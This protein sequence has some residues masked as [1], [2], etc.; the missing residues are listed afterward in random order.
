MK[1][2][3]IK[4]SITAGMIISLA[5]TGCG[6]KEIKENVEVKN[7]QTSETPETTEIP[8]ASELP[9]ETEQTY[10]KVVT[11]AKEYIENL[12]Y[13]D[14]KVFVPIDE[15][16]ETCTFTSTYDEEKPDAIYQVTGEFDLNQDEKADLIR[17]DIDPET[18]DATLSV[19]D[20][21]V[22]DS[23]YS[24]DTMKIVD[25]DTN[26]TYKEIVITDLGPSYD[27]TF[28][29]Y[30]YDGSSLIKLGTLGA[31]YEDALCFDGY[32]RLT[33]SD[34]FLYDLEPSIMSMYYDYNGTELTE[35][36]FDLTQVLNQEYTL[37]KT[38]DSI[39]FDENAEDSEEYMPDWGET[40]EEKKL[41][42]NS[43]DKI[44]IKHIYDYERF[45][46]QLPDGRNGM[47]YFWIGD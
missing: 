40:C 4:R 33:I 31:M 27:P 18:Q 22:S 1:N 7:A 8:Q 43:G 10:Q 2:K 14:S 30:R 42:L 47:M 28:S 9:L 20:I 6:K 44:T 46:V 38:E 24:F 26:D 13:S 16:K 11:Y 37:K 5:L 36:K 45:Y 12:N 3:R 34:S 39:Y 29:L 41:T 17:L 25:F 19:N 35:H 15:A 21:S 23:F 32:G